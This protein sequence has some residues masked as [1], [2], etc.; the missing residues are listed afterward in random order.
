[1]PLLKETMF[2]KFSNRKIMEIPNNHSTSYQKNHPPPL[3]IKNFPYLSP[4]NIIFDE[5]H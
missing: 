1:M 3:P 4:A 2:L 5:E